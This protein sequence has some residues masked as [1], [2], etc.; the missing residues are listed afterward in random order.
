LTAPPNLDL[1]ENK[2]NPFYGKKVVI[3][4]TYQKWTN[5][6]D[7]AKILKSYGA[8]IDTSI[9]KKTNILCAGNG[10]G[11]KKL[12]KMQTRIDKGEEAQILDEQ[13]LINLLI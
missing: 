3:S 9:T 2:N 10:V 5:R 12:E 8:D 13:Q 7:L 1:I 4:G 11:P 6:R